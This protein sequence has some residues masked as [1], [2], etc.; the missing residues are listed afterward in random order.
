MNKIRNLNLQ[1]LIT[2]YIKQKFNKFCKFEKNDFISLLTMQ[3][4]TI[5]IIIFVF[6]FFWGALLVLRICGDAECA[7]EDFNICNVDIS[8]W[9]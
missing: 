4:D 8:S 9:V 1:C 2:I 6:S 7:N 3:Y 5:F